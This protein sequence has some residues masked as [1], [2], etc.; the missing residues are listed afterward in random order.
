VG[1]AKPMHILIPSVPREV[2][3]EEEIRSYT[4]IDTFEPSKVSLYTFASK[5]EAEFWNGVENERPQATGRSSRYYTHTLRVITPSREVATHHLGWWDQNGMWSRCLD[6]PLPES[7]TDVPISPS[8]RG[9]YS[10]ESNMDESKRQS[11]QEVDTGNVFSTYDEAS[12]AGSEVRALLGFR[13]LP[14]T[15]KRVAQSTKEEWTAFRTWTPKSV[16]TPILMKND[17]SE[18]CYKVARGEF[19]TLEAAA[20]FALKGEKIQ[21]GPPTDKWVNCESLQETILEWLDQRVGNVSRR[22]RLYQEYLSTPETSSGTNLAMILG[23]TVLFSA[24]G[25]STSK[26]STR[27]GDVTES[28]EAR[29]EPPEEVIEATS[30][31]L[32]KDQVSR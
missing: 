5:K 15:H 8:L 18:P 3:P 13:A 4:H 14:I 9:R 21:I 12:F 7:F 10:R 16:G 31:L 11:Y 32:A 24:L 17:D 20:Y 28:A 25:L 2:I 23:A 30:S 22:E 27:V 1:L 6:Q 26:T 29:T 19:L